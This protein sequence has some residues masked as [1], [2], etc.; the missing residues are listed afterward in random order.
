VAEYRQDH[1]EL[2]MTTHP[3]TNPWFNLHQ[4]SGA[5]DRIAA[6]AEP[7][8]VLIAG[9]VLSRIALSHFGATSA[10]HYLYDTP[11]PDFRSAASAQFV[12]LTARYGIVFAIAVL[13]GFVRGRS[14]AVS[15]GLTL[16]KRGLARLV[17]TGI[18]I[19][20]V[21]TLPG[22]IL[23]LVNQYHQLGPGTR[24]W[25]LEARVPWDVSFWLYLAVGSYLVVPIF[26][27][28]FTRGY[29]LGRVRESFSPGGSLLVA[30]VFFAVAHGQYRHIDML[31]VGAEVSL[32][33]WA[34]IVAYSVLRTASLLPAII[35]HA[36]SNVPM[37]VSFRWIVL[38]LSLLALGLWLKPVASWAYG[39]IATLRQIDDW[40]FTL[41]AVTAVV[42]L[43]VTVGAT[44]LTPYVYIAMLGFLSFLG[45]RHRSA[46]RALETQRI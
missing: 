44:S 11:V 33:V 2:A 15:Y 46:W 26:E 18:L 36:I 42:L 43:L 5:V 31:A 40:L 45:V 20:L 19:G 38:A 9:T 34:A 7:G 8:F 28:F 24:F 14:S 4:Q 12:Y 22:Q 17:G 16:G 23:R 39:I 41:L 3:N 10:D 37:T 32:F 35:G 1:S 29:L 6:I 25:A 21:A 30:S 13:L 27:E